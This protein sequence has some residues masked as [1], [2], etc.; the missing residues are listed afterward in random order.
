[1]IFSHLV[2]VPLLSFAAAAAWG[3]EPVST[4]PNPTTETIVARMREA[5]DRSR[6]QLRPYQVVRDYQLFG[7]EQKSQS[8]VT[9]YIDYA[10]PGVQ[11][12]T[13]H[14]NNGTSLGEVIVRK[15][16]ES[17]KEILTNQSAADISPANYS[18]RFLRK[19]V[20]NRQPCYVLELRP[21]RKEAKLLDGIVWI[22]AS[23]YLI[24]RME[25]KPARAP[26]WWVHN[27][28]V[29]LDFRAVHGMWLQ[30]ALRSTASVRLLGE[31][32]LI[33]RDVEYKMGELEA[34][35]APVTLP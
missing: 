32:T 8:E 5:R 24:A 34:L 35:A 9:A 25:G 29:A 13:T 28:E 21:L 31:H 11:H 7:K 2:S 27:I 26:S 30:T 6:A 23:S 15:I 12:F 10:P 22:D 16:L 19:D 1:V 18:F 3:A 17:E 33:S 20:L 14:K 4:I